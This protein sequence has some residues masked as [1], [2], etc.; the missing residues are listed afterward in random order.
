MK[1]ELKLIH[2]DIR[3]AEC[4]DAEGIVWRLKQGGFSK[5][6]HFTTSASYPHAGHVFHEAECEPP[7]EVRAALETAI[8][9]PAWW[10]E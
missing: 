3:V 2:P 7:H 10:A 9:G 8:V 6:S 4:V 5:L 1:A